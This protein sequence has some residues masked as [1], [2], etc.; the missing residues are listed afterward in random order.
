MSALKKGTLCVIVAGCPEN[1]G[2]IVEVVAHLG[3]HEGR[4]DAYEV[5]TVT[6]RKFNQLW[7][8]NELVPGYSCYA[9]T[10]R[11]KLR[12]LIE[13]K[14]D[15]HSIVHDEKIDVMPIEC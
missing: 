4:E 14:D 8:G 13:P 10:D 6:E 3:R 9:I 1:I 12:P 5:K 15:L 2:I 7:R 11:Y